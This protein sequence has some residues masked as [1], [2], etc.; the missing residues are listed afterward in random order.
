MRFSKKDY[1]ELKQSLN[2]ILLSEKADDFKFNVPF[3]FLNREHPVFLN[4]YLSLEKG[5]KIFFKKSVPHI[6]YKLM[7]SLFSLKNKVFYLKMPSKVDFLF[8]S[9][10][11]NI[12]QLEGHSD[13]YYG[14]LVNSMR[15]NNFNCLVVK[16]NHTRFRG[17]YE[18]GENGVLNDFI[19]PKTTT[20]F[21]EL[22]FLHIAYLGLKK[23]VR[24]T[25]KNNLQRN[26]FTYLKYAIYSNQTIG[27]LRFSYIIKKII[28]RTNPTFVISTFEGHAYERQIFRMSKKI[29]P[30]ITNI[31]YQHSIISKYANTINLKFPNEHF[32]PDVI[33]C[34][35]DSSYNFFKKTSVFQN[36]PMYILGS[37]KANN[38]PIISFSSKHKKS[39]CLIVPEGI[40][41]ECMHL[42]NLSVHC[43]QLLP[44]VQFYFR[45]HPIMQLKEII[46]K[47]SHRMEFPKNLIFSKSTLMEDI[48]CS[49]WVV[50]R[51]ST[52]VFNAIEQGLRPIYLKIIGE[53]MTID[54]LQG[55]SIGK[56]IIEKG[57]DL[58]EIIA[59]DIK[60]DFKEYDEYQKRYLTYIKN[61]YSN[62]D[63][64]VLIDIGNNSN[65]K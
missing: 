22:K 41:S 46:R 63:P 13:P 23:L 61:Q 35:G 17:N 5:R 30:N 57:E 52:A 14:T 15:E 53:E 45:L 1:F 60:L 28:E 4:K 43:A 33:L 55:L 31:A 44:S 26:I 20:F 34:M 16:I 39:S 2:E 19:I 9:H 64:K 49:S 21:Q 48:S 8:I 42:L 51:G 59:H 18:V 27:I 47:N 6:L 62:L 3:L 11:T 25:F 38:S 36:L 58:V 40:Y 10:F 7:V 12:N 54:P 32:N 65:L 24:I 37:S 50:Y 56:R 29:N